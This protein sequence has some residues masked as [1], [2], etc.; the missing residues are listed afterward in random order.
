MFRSGCR[1]PP[2]GSRLVFGSS[3]ERRANPQLIGLISGVMTGVT[4]GAIGLGADA[5]GFALAALRAG[6]FF[7]AFFEDFFADFFEDFFLAAF[8]DDFFFAAFF[9]DVFFFA[10]RFFAAFFLAV[11]FFAAGFFFAAFF[12]AAMSIPFNV[13]RLSVALG[14]P[15]GLLSRYQLPEFASNEIGERILGTKRLNTLVS[16][17]TI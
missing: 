11:F 6:F 3:L 5:A 16:R 2:V 7:A 4:A 12:F 17:V 8:F 15:G 13:E 9:F 14:R 1:G 10:T